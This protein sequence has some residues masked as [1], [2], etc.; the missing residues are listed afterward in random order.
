MASNEPVADDP[1]ADDFDELFESE[2]PKR[3]RRWP[4]I[5]VAVVLLLVAVAGWLDVT[6]HRARTALL[7]ERLAI[8]RVRA[9]LVAGR[10]ATADMRAAQHDADHAYSLTHDPVWASTAWLR[11]VS[12]VRQLTGIASS[13]SHQ[14][15]PPLVKIGPTVEPSKLRTGPHRLNLAPLEAAAPTLKAMDQRL[16][17]TRAKLASV[18]D[19]W[20]GSIKA[21]REKLSTQLASL[22]GS[23]DDAARFARVGPSML[24]ADGPR[25]YFVGI[26]NN[27]E[28]KATG[29]LVAAYAIVTVNHGR[30][31]VTER[32]NDT[33][34][35][36]ASQPVTGLGHDY[37]RQY[38][39][40]STRHWTTSN[41]S[42]NFPTVARI[43][44]TLWQ[45]QSGQH[46][47]GA[48]AV[49]PVALSGMLSAIGPV[50]VAGYS[51]TFSGTNLAT[52]IEAG[53][54][55]AF[56]G[57]NAAQRK[58]FVSEVAGA[59]LDR[60]LSGAG[61]TSRLVDVLGRAAGA[62]HLQLWSARPEE[63]AG[64]SGTPLAGELPVTTGPFA[65]VTFNDGVGS[66]LDYYLKRQLTYQASGCAA[67]RDATI[68]VG[69]TNTAPRTGLPRY[70]RIRN[71]NGQFHV[72]K[73]PDER[74]SVRV[75]ASDG[76]TLTRATFAGKSVTMTQRSERGHPVFER[77][78]TLHPGQ[79]RDLVLHLREPAMT[80]PAS[81][82]VQ[83]M[84][85]A[86]QTRLDVP[87]C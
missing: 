4:W 29:G 81:T 66:K 63:E 67:N 27:A 49:D 2:P 50:K 31:S 62:G 14:V 23:L 65:A 18:P 82:K 64:I 11:P 6:A 59:V 10:D 45:A 57:A 44:S 87:A 85:R 8:S 5:V 46:I 80:G 51:Q 34:L 70:V 77:T 69:M 13:L 74:L 21:G 75:Y 16:S 86:Q 39:R 3:R 84:F 43:W 9:D 15:L 26:Q 79:P 32:G 71:H 56:Q 55:R 25:R 54:Y 37:Y 76:A 83:P 20:F 30:V 36:E 58:P 35:L 33:Q 68:T 12:V 42:P 47:D 24:G 17:A 53:E 72:E 1:F 40:G 48:F 22:Q 28:T 19:G 60:L 78:V 73:V 61:S 7:N 52:F 38:G 41:I